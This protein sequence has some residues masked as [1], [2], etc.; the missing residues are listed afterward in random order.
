MRNSSNISNTFAGKDWNNETT[1]SYDNV[2]TG[3]G[4]IGV[5]GSPGELLLNGDLGFYAGGTIDQFE[6]S[7]TAGSAFQFQHSGTMGGGSG[8]NL[9]IGP[10]PPVLA[11]IASAASGHGATG[12]A[13]TIPT[14]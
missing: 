7:Y 1:L 2:I 14:N 6:A 4:S 10:S 5:S 12:G 3:D 11:G 13:G 9:L 8:W